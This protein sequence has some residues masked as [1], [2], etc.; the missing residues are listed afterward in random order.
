MF[1]ISPLLCTVCLSVLLGIPCL[2]RVIWILGGY[3]DES[4]RLMVVAC[5]CNFQ[6]FSKDHNNCWASTS[7]HSRECR[8]KERKDQVE[9]VSREGIWNNCHAF[10]IMRIKGIDLLSVS[11]PRRRSLLVATC[12]W[13]W[14][15]RKEACI[16][17][18]AP[19]IPFIKHS[20]LSLISRYV[21][22]QCRFAVYS[23]LAK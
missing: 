4:E 6:R 12:F 2:S 5:K 23:L 14:R 10:V 21:L 15:G 16:S 22:L 19:L 20:T 18:V 3:Q 11:V 8:A 13:W 7:L 1:P 17:C 9:C